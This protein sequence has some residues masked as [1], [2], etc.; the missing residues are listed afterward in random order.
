MQQGV[1]YNPNRQP[2]WSQGLC[3]IVTVENERLCPSVITNE[4]HS[5]SAAVPFSVPAFIYV[6]E[7]GLGIFKSS[8]SGIVRCRRAVDRGTHVETVEIQIHEGSHQ[9]SGNSAAC[10]SVAGSIP[11]K[12]RPEERGF[13]PRNWWVRIS[14]ASASR[15]EGL[16]SGKDQGYLAR[17]LER[18]FMSDQI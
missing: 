1:P 5:P 17:G 10:K 7:S 8:G 6:M 18:F 2:T 9:G 15:W 14:D 3:V 13:Q 4:V 11:P 12:D 16:N